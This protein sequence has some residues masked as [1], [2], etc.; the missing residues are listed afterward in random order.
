MPASNPDFQKYK[1]GCSVVMFITWLENK[2]R[3]FD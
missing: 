1:A 3:K 2:N